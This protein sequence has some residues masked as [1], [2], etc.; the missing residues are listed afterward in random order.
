M[1]AAAIMLGV[2]TLAHAVGGMI[3]MV[4]FDAGPGANGPGVASGPFAA[5]PNPQTLIERFTQSLGD[6]GDPTTM[7]REQIASEINAIVGE[8]LLRTGSISDADRGRLVSLVAA[9]FG[10]TRDEAGQRLARMEKDAK[11]RLGEIEGR[12]VRWLTKWRS[13]PPGRASPVHG[14]CAGSPRRAHRRLAR[15]PPQ[16]PASSRGGSRQRRRAGVRPPGD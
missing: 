13:M 16:T 6:S 5:T 9:Q 4:G 12:E 2:V 7:S 15:R 1:W 10:L 14:A 11:T 3:P 8:N